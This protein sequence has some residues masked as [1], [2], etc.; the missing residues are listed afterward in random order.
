MDGS[1]DQTENAEP[2]VIVAALE[3][4]GV[5]MNQSLDITH[6]SEAAPIL[7]RKLKFAARDRMPELEDWELVHFPGKTSKSQLDEK[8]KAQRKRLRNRRRVGKCLSKK[9]QAVE[10]KVLVLEKEKTDWDIEKKELLSKSLVISVMGDQFTAPSPGE[11]KATKIRSAKLNSPASS[12]KK[13]EMTLQEEQECFFCPKTGRTTSF[14][15]FGS[16]QKK[17]LFP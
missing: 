14:L 13:K 12:K 7:K 4:T 11:S 2:L 5:E 3:A 10:E 1:L 8:E 6:D 17:S 16:F 9:L 15:L